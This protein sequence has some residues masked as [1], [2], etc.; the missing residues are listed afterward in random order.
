[1]KIINTKVSIIM[2]L[3]NSAK[4]LESTLE[5]V[6]NQTYKNWELIIVD[7][8]SSDNSFDLASN[9]ATKDQRIILKRLKEKSLYGALDVR[10]E[11]LKYAS[12]RYI[13]FLDSDDLWDLEFLEKQIKF[14]SDK[15]CGFICCSYRRT[16]GKSTDIYYVNPIIRYKDM[17]KSNP[18]SCLTAIYDLEIVGEK[19]FM[20]ANSYRREDF[21]CFL[22]IIKKTNYIAYGNQEVLA[23]YRIH[24]NST[25]SGKFKLIKYQY[26]IYRKVERFNIFLSIYYTLCW[27]FKGYFKYRKLK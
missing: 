18:I 21:A 17:L 14:M 12:G 25:S 6:I 2:P 23:T 19:I 3:Y 13:A 4:Y 22:Q 11:C 1:M 15:K 20:P 8:F 26:N 16:T 5:S 27:S 24:K 10:N 7:D 9:F